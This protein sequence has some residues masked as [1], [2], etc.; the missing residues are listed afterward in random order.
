MKRE[1]EL[2]ILILILLL[3]YVATE[4]VFIGPCLV[5]EEPEPC[6][7]PDIQV[8]LFTRR[9]PEVGQPIDFLEGSDNLTHSH[10]NPRHSNKLILHGFNS[11][12]NEEVL[13]N[14]KKEYL[15][16]TNVNVF[17]ANYPKLVGGVEC[18]LSAVSNI[19]HIGKCLAPVV[20]GLRRHRSFN[21]H[22]IGFSLG[23]QVCNHVANTL[24]KHKLPRITGLDPAGPDFTLREEEERLDP[25]DARFVDVIHTNGGG[26][27]D[28]ETC[29]H[30]DF[31]VNGGSAQPGCI[32][33]RDADIISCNHFRAPK[34]F[35]E[36]INSRVGFLGWKCE[37][38]LD[39][40]LNT[41]EPK[42]P[43]IP[44]G[45]HCPIGSSGV[46]LVET[47]LEEPFALGDYASEY[48]QNRKPII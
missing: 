13:Q 37:D 25:S 34:Y 41:C 27:G 31:Y 8:F 7:D 9:N 42:R 1:S 29:G 43:L 18:Y 39:I 35:A 45:E 11:D 44:M 38:Y 14:I 33:G 20:T 17:M 23:G 6:P 10:F 26:L 40:S 24:G 15:K 16:H 36:S 5:V 46:Y 32:L 12:M 30:I 22:V 3:G 21:I 47:A 2:G 28:I 48:Y 19:K 4:K